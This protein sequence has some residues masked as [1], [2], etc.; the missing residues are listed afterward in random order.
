MEG[1]GTESPSTV[2]TSKEYPKTYDQWGHAFAGG[3]GKMGIMVFGDPLKETVIFNDRKFNMA[4]NDNSPKRHINDI[5]KETVDE[6]TQ[7]FLDEEFREAN[8]KANEANGWQDG[9]EQSRHPGY[10]MKINVLGASGEV[11]DYQRSV[12]YSTGEIKVNWS[13]GRGAWERKTF[14]SRQDNVAVS[15]L[16]GPNGTGQFDV[17]LQLKMED[18]MGM[19]NVTVTDNS[20]IDFLNIRV[21]Y[22]NTATGY[23]GVSKID[24]DGTKSIANGIV[25]VKN[26]TYVT[27]L[28]KNEKY[29]SDTPNVGAM[30]ESSTIVAGGAAGTNG[31]NAQGVQTKLNAL[32]TEYDVLM[33]GQIATHKEIFDRVGFDLNAPEADR[34]KTNEE[35]L[36]MQEDTYQPVL[37]LYEKVFQAGRYHYLCSSSEHAAPDL[38]GIWTGDAR[39]GW[40]G[41][42]HLDANLNVQIASGNI[43][44]MPEAMAGYFYLMDAWKEGFRENAYKLLKTRGLV[45]GGNTPGETSGIISDIREVYYPYQYVTGEMGWLL[46]PLWEH[47]LITRDEDFLRDELYP[48]LQEMGHF[49]E[50]FLEH[51]DENGK[52]IFAGSVS[53]EAATAGAGESWQSAV[54]NSTFDIHGAIFTLNALLEAC[55]I[56]DIQEDSTNNNITAWKDRLNN[57]PPTLINE[58]GAISEWSW[59]GRLQERTVYSHR[60]SSSLIGAWPFNNITPEKTPELYDAARELLYQKDS[61]GTPYESKGHGVTHGALHA[62]VLNDGESVGVKLVHM[63]RSKFYFDGFLTAHDPNYKTFCTDVAN[64]VPGIMM[65]MCLSS[66]ADN[67]ELLPAVPESLS[68]GR[69]SGLKAKNQVTVDNLEWN[70][71]GKTKV[72]LTSAVDKTFDLILRQGIK[73]INVIS[74]EGASATDSDLGL[75]AKEVT[76]KAGKAATFELDLVQEIDRNSA[77]GKV[78]DSS[79]NQAD[80]SKAVDAN[81]S[82]NWTAIEETEGAWISVDLGKL[83]DLQSIKVN[84]A[85]TNAKG[86]EIETSKSGQLWTSIYS[87]T[88]ANGSPDEVTGLDTMARFI[89]IKNTDYDGTGGISVSEIEVYGTSSNLGEANIALKRPA[90]G[91]SADSAERTGEKAVDGNKDTRW[92]SAYRIGETLTVDL[93]RPYEINGASML[94]EAAFAKQYAIEVSLDNENWTTVYTEGNG[95]GRQETIYFDVIEGARYVRIRVIENAINYGMSLWEFEVY[96][97]ALPLPN[98]AKDKP[99]Q[100]SNWSTG[101]GEPSAA[102]DGNLTTRWG[103]NDNDRD[104][105]ILVDLEDNYQLIGGKINWEASYAKQYKIE[106]SQDKNSWTEIRRQTEGIGGVEEFEFTQGEGRYVRITAIERSGQYSMSMWEIEFYGDKIEKEKINVA[107]DKPAEASTS[108]ASA[109]EPGRAVDGNMSTRWGANQEDRDEWI[110]IDLQDTY[111]LSEAV[112]HWEDSYAKQYKIQASL[113]K[114]TWKD[115]VVKTDSTG[116][117][118]VLEIDK[119]VAR[120]VRI[121]VVERFNQY[122]MSLYEI[123]LYGEPHEVETYVVTYD[124]NGGDAITPATKE[125]VVGATYGA[126]PVPTRTGYD[127]VGW[128]TDQDAGSEVEAT[129][130]VTSTH[131]I[132]ARWSTIPVVKYTITY[133]VNGGDAIDP[134]TKEVEVGAAYGTLPVP[135]RDGYDFSGWYTDANAG[136]KVEADTLVNSTHEIY[137]RWILVESPDTNIAEGKAATASTTSSASESAD[138]AV[139]GAKN[140]RWTSRTTQSPEWIYVDLGATYD[141]TEMQIYWEAAHAKRYKIQVAAEGA[142]LDEAS[143]WVDAYTE[144]AET[145]NVLT[146]V[147]G[148]AGGLNEITFPADTS[149]RY[150]RMYGI[151]KSGTDGFSIWEL[152]IYGTLFQEEPEATKYTITYDVNGGEAISPATKEVADGEDYGILPTP[153]RTGYTFDG[154]YTDANAGVM[155]DADTLVVSSHTI[156]ARWTLIPAVKYTITYDANGGDT[157]T[158]ATKEVE[159]GEA[160]GTL[161]V[162]TRTGYTFDG[163]YTDADAG[164]KVE[165]TT[166]VTSTHTIYARWTIIPVVKYTITYDANGGDAITP[167]TK[168][169]ADGEAYGILPVPTRTGYNFVGWYTDAEAGSLVEETDV[170]TSNS[171][172]YARWEE[173]KATDA[174][175]E[176]LKTLYDACVEASKKEGYKRESIAALEVALQ[177]AQ[178]VIGDSNAGVTE[179]TQAISSLFQAVGNMEKVAVPDDKALKMGLQ[180]TYDAMATVKNEDYTSASWNKLQSV[181]ASARVTLNTKGISEAEIAKANAELVAAF[182]GLQKNEAKKPT[183][184]NKTP[185]QIVYGYMGGKVS[186]DY[187]SASWKVFQNAMTSAKAILD[188][189][190]ATDAQVKN[191]LSALVT[192]AEGLA[193]APVPTPTAAPKAVTIKKGETFTVGSL[194]YKVSSVSGKTVTV[195]G[196]KKKSVTSISIPKTVKYKNTTFKVNRVANKAFKNYT[197]LKKVTIGA[198]V[199][200]IGKEAF[201]GAKKLKSIIIKGKNLKKVEGKAFSKTHK[202]LVI[203]VP[204]AKVKAYKKLLNKKG[205]SANTVIKK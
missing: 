35:L 101:A 29:Y 6:I 168:E 33:A 137:A 86:Y 130:V 55:D 185:L 116:G 66:D 181:L 72:T 87:K 53:P 51:K 30:L 128:Y 58:A 192:A 113:D 44:N 88:N 188:S 92:A 171:T 100:A 48:Y 102:F 46:Y 67:L 173:E 202:K 91:S 149:A 175:R 189:P 123:E 82:T 182:A 70:L 42:Y 117:T 54:N 98:I 143:S 17:D 38:L 199:T 93:G 10:A 104:E 64:A 95:K 167:A 138:K 49:Y 61:V 8:V 125:V 177:N 57:L 174:D 144:Y 85:N 11:E 25:S 3:D 56:L 27:L 151:Q 160:Y 203:K 31:W 197:K 191:A 169:V 107:K 178:R 19:G 39:V 73:G 119:E 45:A 96:G 154:W 103:T 129:T 89:R 78:V 121:Q 180:T 127:F 146:P 15:K 142:D 81:I 24:T 205:Q 201:A 133:N 50:D 147:E 40:S 195:T 13:D 114:E 59:P 47:Y 90:V 77:T 5:P 26:A 32:S 83:Y 140:T 60:H 84:W 122:G 110:L 20:S 190:T 105:W 155:V 2:A 183:V 165:A 79:S 41:Y 134:A 135:T 14:V 204:K 74:G 1:G 150:V 194:K 163:W 159:D 153:T 164:S 94:W 34:N 108:S 112:L 4:A 141:L 132:Y 71:K 97:T 198:N 52:Y 156:Y 161:P 43:G 200:H 187:T 23:E 99:A 148:L 68:T 196:A 65:E 22:H 7:H 120:Y 176:L 16:T 28:T 186:K 152:E 69:I 63:L 36:R 75:I 166:A 9:G 37:A 109:G 184:V 158:P 136:I 18:G 131:T 21:Q 106:V 139:D 193:P 172:I 179:V 80:A 115:I 162:P 118:D 124:T 76:L 170:V 157:I 111:E 126:L 62:T 12:D 145:D